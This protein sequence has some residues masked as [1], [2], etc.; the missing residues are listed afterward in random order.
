MT[1]TKSLDTEG[2]GGTPE[3]EPVEEESG[4]PVESG[5]EGQSSDAE[6]GSANAEL[7][8]DVVFEVLR[9]QR[10]RHVLRYLGDHEEEVVSLGE[11]AEH[12][13]AQE[14]DKTVAELTSEER[15]R[16][17][18]GLYQCH[19]P[20]MDDMGVISYNQSRGLIRLT[21]PTEQLDK[22]LDTS[23]E[24]LDTPW[25]RY[26]GSITA[27]S[28]LAF[29]GIAVNLFPPWVSPTATLGVVSLAFTGCSVAHLLDSRRR[30]D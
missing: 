19:L 25:V 27:V 28:L 23:P 29:I 15:K 6:D 7:P 5:D 4:P 16:V 3:S 10:R 17:Y 8:L 21:S 18:V 24:D 1:S 9:N 20:K 22:Y 14:N 12:V 26:Y 2:S 13:A 30:E 11:L